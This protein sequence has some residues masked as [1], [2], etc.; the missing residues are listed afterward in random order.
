M[1][2]SL[3]APG[4]DWRPQ[5]KRFECDK[6]LDRLRGLDEQTDRRGL[7][8]LDPASDPLI[9]IGME[10]DARGRVVR[11]GYGLFNLGWQAVAH[12]EWADQVTAEAAALRRRF[13]V[14]GRSRLRFVIWAGMGGSIEDKSMYEAVGLLR[15]PIRF[16]ALDSTDPGKL[17][18][19]LADIRRRSGG[20]L[21]DA[22][23]STLVVGMALGMTSYEPVVNLNALA[24]LYTREK[25]DARSHFIYLTLPGSLLE[26][27][28]AGRGF[29]RVALQL[30]GR[31]TTSGRHS[32][33][34]T[35]GSLL[36]LALA[37]VDMNRWLAGTALTEREVMSAWKLAAFLHA[38]GVAGRDKVTL[39]LPHAWRGAAL[40]TKQDF[41]ESL[42]KSEALGIKI[43]INDD[44][45]TARRDRV[46]VRVTFARA[47]AKRPPSFPARATP[48]AALVLPARSALSRYMQF[49]HYVV[50]GIA[51]LRNMNFVTQPGVE[52]YKSIAADL[53]AESARAGG[54]MNTGAWW[55][56]VGSPRQKTWRARLTAY[57]DG[58]GIET[59]GQDAA[60]E[61][62]GLL[63]A[64][65]KADAIDY[66]ELTFFGDMR[67]QPSGRRMAALLAQLGK[68]VFRDGLGMH[69]DVYEGPAMNHSYHEMIIG[70]GR[71]LSTI[72]LSARQH[73]IPELGYQ[74]D[75][76][77]AQFL[78]T[79]LA[80]ARRGRPVVAV[81][82]NDLNRATLAAAHE[83]MAAAA[84]HVA[85]WRARP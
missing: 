41:E 18:A 14:S 49:V 5:Y 56:M 69:A 48:A 50:F 21:A 3:A 35:R 33:P 73:A 36:P 63:I 54:P 40:W 83:F 78:A 46:R 70:H 16:Y 11:N 84:A 80:L 29:T 20:T 17:A 13:G 2:V 27:F 57:F 61:Y 67:Y 23:R 39:S 58:A 42:G 34:L 32:A 81:V 22:L 75:Y 44:G 79:K 76:H 15:G 85:R 31:H 55:A 68:R 66:G 47:G 59:R 19:I 51:Y 82:L 71:C 30:D 12:P 60:E 53:H 62:A 24:R 26:V 43:V 72:F 7:D 25:I 1:E 6:V 10:L 45:V 9:S 52:L 65:A 8:T 37:G 28:A 64:L 38:A 74:A 4:I 77:V